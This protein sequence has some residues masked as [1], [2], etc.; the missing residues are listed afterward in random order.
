MRLS[1]ARTLAGDAL[2]SV[3]SS[4][5]P[6]DPSTTSVESEA[7]TPG[8][9]SSSMNVSTTSSTRQT[10][11]SSSPRVSISSPSSS[12]RADGTLPPGVPLLSRAREQR[13]AAC[14][15]LKHTIDAVPLRVIEK[16]WASAVPSS[17]MSTH[18]GS[19]AGSM[20]SAL[21]LSPKR[22]SGTIVIVTLTGGGGAPPVMSSVS[23]AASGAPCRSPLKTM[24]TRMS[25][26]RDV[27]TSASTSRACTLATSSL[28]S[29]NM[30]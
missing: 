19:S 17:W 11:T 1:M 4:A 10:S 2:L 9:A 15:S 14:S 28:L 16:Y 20:K 5:P 26:S 8:C 6:T 3:S 12:S 18:T 7:T 29:P 22:S 23:D 25:A 21:V 24:A 13:A 27:T 30:P